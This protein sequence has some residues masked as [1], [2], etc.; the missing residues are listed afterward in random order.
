VITALEFER[1]ACAGGPTG[2]EILLKN[3]KKP[4]SVAILHCVGSRD[5][6]YHEYCSR[7][8][9]MYALKDAHLIREKTGA[10]VYQM[11]IDMRCFG[12]GYE[13]FYKRLSDEGIRFVR[14]KAAEVTD[15]ALTDEEKG[16]LVVVCEDTLLGSMLRVP[17]DMVILCIALE[18]RSDVEQVAR[19]FN[20]SRR[21]DGF[22]QERHLKLDPVATPTGGV[23][24]IGSCAGPK[25][26]TDTVSQALGGAAE[27][28]AL[29]G[30]GS[31]TLE[32]AVSEVCRYAR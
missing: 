9:C 15:E 29:I 18:P 25:D 5:E 20:I 21:P 7:V 28:L 12:E 17:V 4:E 22:F 31:V 13:E 14:G 6:N 1:L 11:Y 32:A 19:Q 3:G 2:G 23:F 27:A 30:K 24:V 26:I 8:C 10:E 16:K